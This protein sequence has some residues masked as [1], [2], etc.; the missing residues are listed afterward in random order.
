MFQID[1]LNEIVN[2]LLKSY[3]RKFSKDIYNKI[4]D[5]LRILSPLFC[6]DEKL[7]EINTEQFISY[8]ANI[9]ENCNKRKD[10]GKYYTPTDLCDFMISKLMENVIVSEKYTI[11]DPTCGNSEFLVAYIK[12]LSKEITDIDVIKLSENIY[13]NDISPIA[14][15]ISKIRL[16]FL[17]LDISNDVKDL[18]VEKIC[19]NLNNNFTELDSVNF[20][21]NY[22]DFFDFVIGNPPYV[23]NNKYNGIIKYE[24]QKY[25]NIY[26]NVL[27][28][29]IKLLKK[30]GKLSFVIP[31]SYVSTPRM[32]G[33]RDFVIKETDWQELYNFADRPGCLF[34]SVHQ[35]LTVIIT[36]KSNN[37]KHKHNIYSSDYLYWYKSERE[38][39]FEEISIYNVENMDLGIPKIG[40]SLSNNIF[41]KVLST[42][43]D[44]S[45]YN[46]ISQT[47]ESIYLNM[48]ATFWIKC[49]LDYARSKE[50]KEF[51]FSKKKLSFIYCLLNSSLFFWFWIS[52]SDGWHITKKELLSIKVPDEFDE[53]IFNKLARKLALDLEKNKKFVNTKQIDYIYQ[54][55]ES[56]SILDEIDYEIGKCYGLETSEIEFIINYAYK[57]R[58]SLGE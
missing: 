6:V 48:R 37:K 14:I 40:S 53:E 28:N 44:D 29:A 39:L 46:A 22:S 11:I 51:T 9:N 34:P 8:T 5:G 47:G 10:L 43:N 35:K 55:K 21:F 25:G 26:A 15:L 32:F 13:G 38:K 7:E 16:Y 50:Y 2:K 52:I 57:Y 27:E 12:F 17:F 45:V 19:K 54:H 23:E 36:Q 49:F 4:V 41:S 31:L 33:I 58:M 18:S 3:E 56:K 30:N 1:Y 42:N 20:E 24:T